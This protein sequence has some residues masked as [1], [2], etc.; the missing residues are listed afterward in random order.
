[1]TDRRNFLHSAASGLLLLKPRTVFGSQANSAVEVGILGLGGRG[2]YIGDFFVEHAG[3]R[4]VAL[5]D[6]F[7]DRL[8]AAQKKFK[9]EDGRLHG[10][11]NGYLAVVG[12]KLDAVVIESP[13]YFHPDQAAAAVAAGKHVYLAK[14]IAVDVSG[15]KSIL[16]SAARA[17]GKL[18]FLIDF[19]TRSQP[20]FQEAAARVH[21]GEIGAPV[22]GH[23]YYHAGRLR[24]K[25]M[26]GMSHDEARLR[27]WVFDKVLSGDIIVEQNIHVLD[28]IN[29]YLQKPPL[30]A[31]GAGGRKARVDVGD[32][33][34]HFQV[35]YKYPGG[36]LV[37]FSS[38]QFTRGFNDLC[39]RLYGSEGT[40]DSHYNGL[41][42]IAGDRPWH[43]TDKD[44]T[45]RQGAI[46]NVKAFVESIR[47]GKPL[48]N[49]E[50]SVESNLV[51]ILGRTAA[52]SGRDVT[53][54][55]MMR[56]NENY[57]ARLAL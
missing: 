19:Q 29:W 13:P 20:V 40:L 55:E 33:W 44:D 41:V 9:V 30:S 8:E 54:D 47:A 25:H 2:N 10:G 1:M 49:A 12:S 31:H 6:P 17:K 39:A 56:S 51:A 27:N 24:P 35:T 3:A 48:N 38:A 52:Y 11:L 32:A 43:G 28:M 45:F 14:P 15:C 50:P 7:R 22:L 57:E 4:V 37:D 46:N 16:A 34:D 21:R 18:S 26:P 36:V 23:V 53:W 42:R 5:A